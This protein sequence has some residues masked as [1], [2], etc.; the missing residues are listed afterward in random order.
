MAQ[1]EL[2][3]LT[4]EEC[5]SLLGTAHVGRL[6]YQDDLGPLAIPVNYA[7]SGSD[8]VFRVEGGTKRHAMRQAMLAFEV[9]V[10]DPDDQSGWSVLVRGTGQEVPAREVPSVL[11]SMQGDFPRPWAAGIHNVWLRI[12]PRIVTGRRLGPR[13]SAPAY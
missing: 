8:I 12:T 7:M 5:H 9:D 10:I 2:E 11:R 6:V 3:D 4:V 1:R 13:H